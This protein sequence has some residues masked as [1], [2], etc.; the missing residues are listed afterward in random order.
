M[1]TACVRTAQQPLTARLIQLYGAFGSFGADDARFVW[2][3]GR[4]NRSAAQCNAR[5]CADTKG[6]VCTVTLEMK[7][8]FSG[9]LGCSSDSAL[10]DLCNFSFCQAGFTLDGIRTD[11]VSG[12]HLN[13]AK[14]HQ[15][16]AL[17]R[18]IGRAQCETVSS[19]LRTPTSSAGLWRIKARQIGY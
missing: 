5:S 11:E 7:R 18:H 12:R 14:H 8:L 13:R 19:H 1:D 16:L 2:C 17:G 3:V 10:A 4:P 6:R 9:A 15:S